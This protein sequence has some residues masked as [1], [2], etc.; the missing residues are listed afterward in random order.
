MGVSVKNSNVVDRLK[1]RREHQRAHGSDDCF[2]DGRYLVWIC[3]VVFDRCADDGERSIEDNAARMLESWH[4]SVA[5][6][7]TSEDDGEDKILWRLLLQKLDVEPTLLRD[8]AKHHLSSFRGGLQLGSYFEWPSFLRNV[9]LNRKQQQREDDYLRSGNKRRKSND[10]SAIHQSQYE[11]ISLS[12]LMDPKIQQQRNAWL[13]LLGYVITHAF[14]SLRDAFN[15]IHETMD[16]LQTVVVPTLPTTLGLDCEKRKALLSGMAA[17]L[18]DAL[19]EALAVGMLSLKDV[20]DVQHQQQLQLLAAGD[21]RLGSILGAEVAQIVDL[22]S[23]QGL[24]SMFASIVG[25][26]PNNYMLLTII[27]FAS[28]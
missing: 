25:F 24:V 1:F 14:L 7:L 17:Y 12:A 13:P 20:D 16:Y 5:K 26:L 3:G 22:L 6:L 28:P 19:G 11:P 4:D 21:S 9:V 2:V 8:V 23:L 27:C 10:G 15:T 18:I